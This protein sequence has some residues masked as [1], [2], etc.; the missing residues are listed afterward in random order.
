MENTHTFTVIVSTNGDD[1]DERHFRRSLSD[2][3]QLM[4]NEGDATPYDAEVEITGYTIQHES[5]I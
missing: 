1:F 4:L 3:I 2:Y 5:S